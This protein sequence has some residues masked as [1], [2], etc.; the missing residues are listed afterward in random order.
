M[1]LADAPR[2]DV[3]D[4]QPRPLPGGGERAAPE[5]PRAQRAAEPVELEPISRGAG[6][7]PAGAVRPDARFMRAHAAHLLAF[8][9]GAGLSRLAPGTVGTIWAWLAWNLLA[10][11]LAPAAL[12]WLLAAALPLAWWSSAVTARH[13]RMADPGV[14][15][16]DEIV[17]FWCVLWLLAPAGFWGQ[18]GAFL[19]FRFFDAA[20]PGPVGWADRLFHG[21]P[22]WRGGLGIV[23]DDLVAAALT[24][25]VMALFR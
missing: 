3:S 15:V 24:L 10:I 4:V 2:D 8:G 16:I 12:G 19:L 11:W 21:Q 20:K 14:I 22:G 1:S 23:L 7:P 5:A 9:F 6:P 13:L 17:A 25:L 18:F